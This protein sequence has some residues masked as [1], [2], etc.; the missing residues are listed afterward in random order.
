ME[1]G[2]K[3]SVSPKKAPIYRENTIGPWAN[4]PTNSTTKPHLLHI[5]W[6]T[7]NKASMNNGGLTEVAKLTPSIN[8][9]ARPLDG[10]ELFLLVSSKG[11]GVDFFF[12]VWQEERTS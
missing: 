8:H 2:D 7:S 6:P 10:G 5:M 12:K 9:A 3:E 1:G 11:K 4:Q